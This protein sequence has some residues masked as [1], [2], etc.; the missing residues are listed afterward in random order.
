[1]AGFKFVAGPT[2][3]Y[4]KITFYAMNG[5]ICV[6][7]DKPGLSPNDQFVTVTCQDFLRR[8]FAISEGTKALGKI[9]A[10]TP[11]KSLAQDR[12]EDQR[13]VADMITC[14]QDAK[15][16]GDLNDPEVW[17]WIERHKSKPM[18]PRDHSKDFGIGRPQPL[19]RGRNTGRHVTPDRQVARPAKS[20]LIL[21][22]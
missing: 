8:A 19:P 16:Q 14:V 10:E 21:P 12:D 5:V 9:I 15:H 17:A 13:L 1:M 2:Y 6:S 20:K 22:T 11:R 7:D 4:R 3:R 18:G